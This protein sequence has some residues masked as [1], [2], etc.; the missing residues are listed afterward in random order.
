MLWSASDTFAGA[1]LLVF[2]LLEIGRLATTAVENHIRVFIDNPISS[3]Y[4]IVRFIL[5]V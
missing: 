1:G 2:E 4:P 3:R 5:P